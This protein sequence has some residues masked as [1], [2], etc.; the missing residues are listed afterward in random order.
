MDDGRVL[1]ITGP[2]GRRERVHAMWLRDACACGGCRRPSS[3]ERL[4]DPTTID[5]DIVIARLAIDG[6]QLIAAMSDGHHV[7]LDLAW[8]DRHLAATDHHDE[9]AHGTDR[10]SDVFTPARFERSE[11][12]EPSACRAWL[13]AIARSGVALVGGVAPDRAGLVDVAHLIGQIRA[14]NYGVTW[15][16]DATVEPVTEVD[17][18]HGLRVH[19]DLPYRNV[20]PGV[21]LLLAAVVEVDGGATTLV[22]GIGIAEELRRTDARAWELLTT[23]EFTYPFV[24]DDVEHHGRAPLIGRRRDGSYHQIRR[25]PDLVGVPHVSADLVPELYGALRR[26]TAAI[27]D[28]AN[29]ITIELAPGD[30]LALHNHRVLHGRTAF[31]LGA[32][33]R[34]RLLG[35]YLD[36][37]DLLSRRAVLARHHPPSPSAV[38]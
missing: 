19:T 36:I 29:A 10:W 27:D 28:P 30:L 20:A 13:D 8:L 6:D 35:C 4:L 24:R 16:I 2:G 15:S 21:Q 9:P 1:A 7:V 25:A 5:A 22:D 33:G 3:N 32:H 31:E 26:W 17:S 38:L 11:L 34:R 12:D 37:E 23:V 18:E 14:T